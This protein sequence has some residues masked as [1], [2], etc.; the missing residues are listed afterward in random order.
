MLTAGWLLWRAMIVLPVLVVI[1]ALIQ[2][3]RAELVGSWR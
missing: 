1:A 2:R 3:L